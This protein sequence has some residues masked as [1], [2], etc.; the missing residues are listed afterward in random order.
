MNRRAVQPPQFLERRNGR[1]GVRTEFVRA[2]LAD[3]AAELQNEVDALLA[4]VE[5]QEAAGQS[6]ESQLMELSEALEAAQKGR[7]PKGV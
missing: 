6:L 5:A 3:L 1:D 4:D 2:E 7:K